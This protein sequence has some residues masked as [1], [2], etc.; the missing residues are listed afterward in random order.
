[1]SAKRLEFYLDMSEVQRNL[2]LLNNK[3]LP[4]KIRAGLSEIGRASCRERV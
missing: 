3:V 4:A 2:A 1:M